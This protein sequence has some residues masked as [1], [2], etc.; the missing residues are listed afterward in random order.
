MKKPLLTAAAISICATIGISALFASDNAAEASKTSAPDSYIA[1]D[2]AISANMLHGAID[3]LFTQDKFS[4]TRAFV[5]MQGGEVVAE[6]YAPGYDADTRF[7]SWS[8]AKSVT[9]VLIGLMV[10][11]GKLVLDAPAPV[12]AWQRPGDARG[13]ITLRQLLHMSSGLNHTEAG[14]PIYESDE[15]R[16][17]FLD[18]RGDM[19]GYAEGQVLEANPGEKFEYS[20]NTSVIL[21]DIMTRALTKSED[22]DVRRKAMMDFMR[23]R[24][25]EPLGMTSMVPEFDRS[26]T[27]IGGSIM[28]ANARDWATFGEFLRNKGSVAGNQIIPRAWF[29]FMLTSSPNDP[30]YG[31]HI[32]LNKKRPAGSDIVLFP[33][34]APSSVFACLGHLGQVVLVSPEKR[35]TMVRLGKTQDDVGRPIQEQMAEILA[36]MPRS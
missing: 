18:G 15:V 31:G 16:M 20:S 3:P 27:M 6:R 34:D 35:V 26:G 13:N 10:A 19:A 12:P 7:I 14:D 29:D 2:A 11:D 1:A 8:M 25:L 21:S 24:L 28:H 32:W 17:L 36:I 30:A 23:G 4:E 9:A 22:P 5:L 33:D